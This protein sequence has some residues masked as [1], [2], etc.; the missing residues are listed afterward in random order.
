MLTAS[1]LQWWVEFLKFIFAV[2]IAFYIPGSL[3]LPSKTTKS[4]LVHS[5]I[6]ILV[7]LTLWGWQEFIFGYLTLRNLTYLYL[8]FCVTVW[9]F[10]RKQ[11]IFDSLSPKKQTDLLLLFLVLLGV[12]IQTLPLWHNGIH[13]QGKGLIFSGGNIEDNLWHASLTNE[14]TKRFPPFGPGL[15]GILMRNYHYWSNLTIAALARVFKLPLFPT[16]FH[17]FPLLIS[18]LLGI[19]TI[20]LSK[21]LNF[22][23]K[24]TRLFVFFNYFGGDLIYLFL[25][26]LRRGQNFFRMSSLEDGVKFLYNPPRAFSF[27]IALGGISLFMLWQKK[28]KTSFGLL[29]MLLLSSTTGFKIYTSIFFAFGISILAL[30]ALLKR[31]WKNFT[32]FLSFYLL[33]AIIYLPV[34][35]GA[36]SL[37][38]APFSIVNNFIVQPTLGLKRWEM[39]RMIFLEDKKYLYNLIFEIAFTLFFL[40]GILGT[41]LLGFF[42]SPFFVIKKLGK[43]LTILLLVGIFLSTIGGLFFVQTTG[44]ANT[45]NFLV[46]AFLFVSILTSLSVVYWQQ[47]LPKYLSSLFV[48]SVILLTIPRV[49]FETIRNIKN[50]FKPEGFL[51]SNEEI[52]L[53]KSIDKPPSLFSRAAV[54][55]NHWVGRNTPYVSLFV[56]RPLLVSGNG[57]LKHF[58]LDINKEEKSQSLIF[59]THNEKI[60]ARELLTNRI[61]YVILYED[62]SIKAT[63]SAYFTSVLIKNKSGTVLEVNR[64]KLIK[65]LLDYYFKKQGGEV[66]IQKLFYDLLEEQ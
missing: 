56:N 66:Y 52:E 47:K 60:L 29:S 2:F 62:H 12:F 10:K 20:S 63:E 3:L 38:W 37:I 51:I 44:G 7:G 23:K 35:V 54:D 43:N 6:A 40:V 57:L 22:N 15:S 45:F 48:I 19:S 31:E 14:I 17:F 18:F 16:Q 9:I 49:S 61:K 53:Y 5:A 4:P 59:N 24:I 28:K 58:R 46:S 39:A 26:I 27:V 21:I 50:F 25:I 34:N 36:G 41:K 42:Q 11:K 30:I 33:F 1:G 65:R 8:V 64:E 32:I 55:P 13:F